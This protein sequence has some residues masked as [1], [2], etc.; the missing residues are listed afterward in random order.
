MVGSYV[1]GGFSLFYA[2]TSFMTNYVKAPPDLS[3]WIPVAFGFVSLGM[4]AFGTWLC[5]A[6]SRIVKTITAIPQSASR[7]SGALSKNTMKSTQPELQLEVEVKKMFPLPF[8]PAR[9]LYVKPGEIALPAPL[10]PSRN[11]KALTAGNELRQQRLQK[12]VAEL[13]AMEYEQTHIM[14]AGIR[15]PLR[16]FSKAFYSF[17]QGTRRAWYREGFMK[18]L[19][20]NQR[21]KL[22]VTGGWALDEGKALDRLSVMKPR[23]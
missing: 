8:I 9:K 23:L 11:R 18:I 20:K 7:V 10:A 2:G 19:V 14:S 1:V 6:P 12:E 15:H 13:K 22:D 21:Y 4:C 16:A 3:P 5:L 17:F